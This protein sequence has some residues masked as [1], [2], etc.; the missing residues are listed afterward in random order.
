MFARTLDKK[1]LQLLFIVFTVQCR[2][3]PVSQE[4]T[5]AGAGHPPCTLTST[6]RGLTNPQNSSPQNEKKFYQ[7]IRQDSTASPG[8]DWKKITGD[9]EEFKQILSSDSCTKTGLRCR[10]ALVS[11]KTRL[12]LKKFAY[13]PYAHT[14]KI[15]EIGGKER[16]LVKGFGAQPFV[17]PRQPDGVFRRYQN[18]YV[19]LFRSRAGDL[20][21]GFI[22]AKLRGKSPEHID[23]I[24]FESPKGGGKPGSTQQVY[25]Q[26]RTFHQVLIDQGYL[27]QV[28]RGYGDDPLKTLYL[29]NRGKIQSFSSNEILKQRAATIFGKD[30]SQAVLKATKSLLEERANPIIL[31]NDKGKFEITKEDLEAMGR[32]L[33]FVSIQNGSVQCSDHHRIM[34]AHDL[35][36]AIEVGVLHG[37]VSFN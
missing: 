24:L 37:F 23:S 3:G 2:Q 8:P 12:T 18:G 29:V 5:L 30:K 20:H 13:A 7:L 26:V 9:V 19:W 11:Q 10:L 14:L 4:S 31:P 6:V 16:I 15:R 36:M 34:A 25:G 17:D 35:G 1:T 32:D 27:R 33:P 28:D 22:L 21:P